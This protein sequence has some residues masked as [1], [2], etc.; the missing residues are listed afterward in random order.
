MSIHCLRQT[1]IGP[2]FANHGPIS[3]MYVMGSTVK[4]A[5]VL[6]GFE[7]GV[8]QRQTI[9]ND[10]PIRIGD[11]TFS[12]VNPMGNIN[13]VTAIERSSNIYMAEIG[14]RLGNYALSIALSNTFVNVYLWKQSGEFI[15]LALYNLASVVFQGIIS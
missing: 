8:V 15:D 12:S 14:L 11:E 3:N 5:T 13:Y 4:P 2:T 6:A 1:L 10:R 7:T 9:I